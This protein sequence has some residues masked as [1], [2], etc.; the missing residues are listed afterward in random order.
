MEALPSKNCRARRQNK[1]DD[2]GK[3]FSLILRWEEENEVQATFRLLD[4]E[5]VVHPKH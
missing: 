2:S 5:L 4:L 1:T 3:S